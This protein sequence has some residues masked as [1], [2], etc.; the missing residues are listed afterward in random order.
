LFLASNQRG[1]RMIVRTFFPNAPLVLKY[2]LECPIILNMKFTHLWC[3][4]RMHEANARTAN[5]SLPAASGWSPSHS[6]KF[7]QSYNAA[8]L[9]F[10]YGGAQIAYSKW[11][12]QW[13]QWNRE[14]EKLQEKW[15]VRKTWRTGLTQGTAATTEIRNQ[16]LE[17]HFLKNLLILLWS[18]PSICSHFILEITI[19]WA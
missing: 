16:Y 19:Y 3:C 14:K 6:V 10:T 1:K 12:I 7:S 5:P 4:Q 11:V 17:M 15:R 18:V 8:K 9:R 13:Q 2:V